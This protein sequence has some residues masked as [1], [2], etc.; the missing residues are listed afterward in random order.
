MTEDS[1]RVSFCHCSHPCHHRHLEMHC[2][3]RADPSGTSAA[4][5]IVSLGNMEK[6]CE[7]FLYDPVPDFHLFIPSRTTYI[8]ASLLA[9]FPVVPIRVEVT[10]RWQSCLP[11]SSRSWWTLT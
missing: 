4:T 5:T 7:R 6:V 1:L 11:K 9:F 8:P 3:A 10:E 2:G